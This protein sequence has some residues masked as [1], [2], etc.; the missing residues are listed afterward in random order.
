MNISVQLNGKP[1][2]LPSI[3]HH[4]SLSGH[5]QCLLAVRAVQAGS[6]LRNLRFRYPIEIQ[7]I[8]LERP[9]TLLGHLAL[10]RYPLPARA[11]SPSHSITLMR[12]QAELVVRYFE[13]QELNV[14]GFQWA[15]VFKPVAEIDDS[16]ALAEP[17]AHDDWIPQAIQDKRRR[18]EVNVAL[19]RIKEASDRFSS[20]VRDI[21]PDQDTPPSAAH[22]GDMLADLLGGLEG[23]APSTRTVPYRPTE[24]ATREST[25]A[26]TSGVIGSDARQTADATASGPPENATV[27][28]AGTA[29]SHP[30]GTNASGGG[31]RDA[32][33][34]VEVVGASHTATAD[35]GW[36]RTTIYVQLAPGARTAAMV[37]VSVRVGVDGGSLDDSQVIRI[38]GWTDSFSGT[39]DPLPQE[40]PPGVIRNFVYEA[41]SDLAI[42]VET[43]LS[44]G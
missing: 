24:S 42:D 14:E 43:K 12:H 23:S 38:V 25:E 2:A 28:S 36:T 15:G 1:I 4:P 34:R 19:R 5:A 27:G 26:E 17:P 31:R 6:D 11:E 37:D 41:R 33:P 7:E 30:S 39:Y 20:P 35:R 13:R 29:S 18:R 21:M 44:E 16:F 9:L 22:V 8:W 40:I 10:A 32:R 3:E